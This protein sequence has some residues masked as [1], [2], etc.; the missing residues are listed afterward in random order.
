MKSRET[1]ADR[2]DGSYPAWTRKKMCGRLVTYRQS[3]MQQ[4]ENRETVPA[5][6]KEM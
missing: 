2:R 3:A 4:L 5:M 1:A 6:F